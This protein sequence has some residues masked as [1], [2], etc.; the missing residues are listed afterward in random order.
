MREGVRATATISSLL[1]NYASAPGQKPVDD[2]NGV[3]QLD[4]GYK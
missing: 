2:Q 1:F 3:Q 4:D